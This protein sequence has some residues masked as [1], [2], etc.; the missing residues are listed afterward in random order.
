MPTKNQIKMLKE[1]MYLSSCVYNMTNYIVRNQFFN[2]EK[3]SSFFD[4]QQQIQYKEDYQMLGRSYGLPRIQQYSE[5]NNARFKLIKSKRQKHVGLPKYYK[6]RKTN[7]TIPSHLLIDN[8]QYSIKKNYICIPLSRQMRKKYHIGK[9]F[10]IKYNGILKHKGK[11]QRGQ[12][13]F[14]DNK[15]YMY[16][17]VEIIDKPI[18]DTNIKAGVDI[19][20]KRFL[21][22]FINNNNDKIIGSKRFLRQWKY[23][24]GLIEKEQRKINLIGKRVS[25]KLIKL[26]R[27]RTK[28]QNNL[29]NN[30]VAKMMR[31]LVRNNV[32][33][34]YI[35]DVKGIRNQ[36]K[37]SK[38]CNQM[39]NNYWSFD[40]L[41]S[42]IENKCQ[43]FGI[44][45]IKI[46]EEYTSITCPIC[47]NRDKSNCKDRI[48]VCSDCDYI[49]H[50]DIVG[51]RNILTKGMCDLRTSTH[52]VEVN[53]LEVII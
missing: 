36:N 49:E 41:Y 44:N 31:V 47:G 27:D 17:S 23:L 2:K 19:G 16:Q 33:E 50:R 26:Y 35:G 18:K 38:I 43:E 11:Q 21:S 45:F 48:F 42:K 25:N 32:S 34:L 28:Y 39:I 6:N 14:K 51:A 3:V 53:P 22:I 37:K 8:S 29:F 1:M 4:L 20:I 46:T 24:T 10:K 7:T 52:W 12:I 15:F 9:T 30:I 13:H 40:K 5:T